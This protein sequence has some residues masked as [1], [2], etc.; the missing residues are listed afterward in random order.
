MTKESYGKVRKEKSMKVFVTG[1]DGMLG[2]NLVRELLSQ[3]IEVRALIEDGSRSPVLNDIAIEKVK[4]N[5]LEHPSMLSHK[6]KGCEVIFHCAAITDLSANPAL[7]WKVNY[8]GTKNLLTAAVDIGARRFIAVSSASVFGFGTKENP[9]DET[10]PTAKIY[11]GVA[12]VES[13]KRA[14]E[15]V[16]KSAREGKIDAVVVAPTFLLGKYDWRPSSGELILQYLKMKI[17]VVTGGG[18]NFIHTSSAAKAMVNAVEKGK[19]GESYILGGENV[20]YK[21][22][23]TLVA[24]KARVRPPRVVVPSTFMKT[25]GA[26]GSLYTVVTRK[27]GLLKYKTACLSLCESY[28][29]SRKAVTELDLPPTNLNTALEDS[30]DSLRSY[31]HWR[32]M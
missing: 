8:E 27:Q 31:G 30:I 6:I 20:S 15:A 7:I 11:E 10:H 28:Y 22:F 18:R 32:K 3:G 1:A 2:A 21:H 4:G 24:E 12:Y 17:P 5:I 9:G 13:K 23:F 25:I 14:T 19:C 29:N 26:V 16:L